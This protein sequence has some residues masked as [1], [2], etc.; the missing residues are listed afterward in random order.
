MS[1]RAKPKWRK[2]KKVPYSPIT[3]KK[4]YVNN[5][6]NW[7]SFEEAVQGKQKYAYDGIGFVFAVEIGIVAIDIDDCISAGGRN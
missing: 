6:S 4:A 1:F 2:D 5:P 3:G 7:V